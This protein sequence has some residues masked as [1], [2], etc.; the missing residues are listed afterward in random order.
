MNFVAFISTPYLEEEEEGDPLVVESV[1]VE[2]CAGVALA[3]ISARSL[4]QLCRLPNVPIET[5]IQN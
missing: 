1:D 2:L 5:P 4:E 3:R